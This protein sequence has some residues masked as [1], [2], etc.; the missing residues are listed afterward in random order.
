MQI[1]FLPFDQ[2]VYFKIYCGI[3]IQDEVIKN[4]LSFYSKECIDKKN[5][6]LWYFIRYADPYEHIRYR[7]KITKSFNA[8]QFIDKLYQLLKDYIS[9]NL[10]YR[11]EITTYQREINRYKEE[12][13]ETVEN[14][15]YQNSLL[16]SSILS[17]K[18]NHYESLIIGIYQ[19]QEALKYINDL[20]FSK[21]LITNQF[22][23]F[24]KEFDV[25]TNKNLLLN[26][27]KDYLEITKV[28]DLFG[29]N[30]SLNINTILEKIIDSNKRSNYIYNEITF[31]SEE[32][33]QN[34]FSSLFHMN[35][36][37]L[38]NSNQRLNEFFIYFS[39]FKLVN[40][41]FET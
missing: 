39:L 16:T 18:L 35:M 25:G 22:L 13:I 5:I 7:I 20:N 4:I 10:V 31:N 1:N 3:K 38:F 40:K 27:E 11:I 29:Q 23:G 28:I 36:N 9:Q 41:N 15:F 26:F 19:I 34:I 8:S 17:A 33:R 32:E 30:I 21:S 37:R 2:W 24:S 14:Y 6:N 12:N